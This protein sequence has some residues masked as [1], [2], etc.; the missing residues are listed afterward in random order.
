MI[1]ARALHGWLGCQQRFHEWMGHRIKEYGFED[2]TDF[3]CSVSKTKGRPRK[4]Y[5][6][7]LDTAKEL[8]MVER[9]APGVEARGPVG[10]SRH[11]YL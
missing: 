8:A 5:L 11:S 4:D 6:L 3:C 9:I 10:R 2:G 1:D 7:T